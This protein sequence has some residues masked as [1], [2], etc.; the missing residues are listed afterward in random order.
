MTPVVQLRRLIRRMTEGAHRPPLIEASDGQRYILK[1]GHLD[2]DFPACELVA[3][4][5]AMS[6]GVRTP[7]VALVEIPPRLLT[8]LSLD[9]DWSDLGVGHRG[10]LCFGSRFLG[11]DIL[12]WTS[13]MAAIT[14]NLP[15]AALGLLALD[16]LIENHDRKHGHNPNV[17]LVRGELVAIDHGQSLPSIQGIMDDIG[18]Q[19]LTQHVSWPL[20]KT[21]PR[22]LAHQAARL[23]TDSDLDRAVSQVPAAW[24]QPPDRP[25]A[26]RAALRRRRDAVRAILLALSNP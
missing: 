13:D 16:L 12:R 17:L 11:D 1:L 9:P 14:T 4:H 10:N 5:L 3:S 8:I 2:P 25:D 15:D 20:V 6:M 7:E 18:E 19:D 26:V 23:P 22:R 21:T 24:W